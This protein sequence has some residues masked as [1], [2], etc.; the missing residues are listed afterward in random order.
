MECKLRGQ[1]INFTAC[2]IIVLHINMICTCSI[3]TIII[4][5]T[6]YS[7]TVRSRV[8]YTLYYYYYYYYYYDSAIAINL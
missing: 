5:I 2:H 6:V 8:Q 3:I 1:S 7:G 4:V